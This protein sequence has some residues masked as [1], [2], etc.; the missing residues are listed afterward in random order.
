MSDDSCCQRALAIKME[1]VLTKGWPWMSWITW[2]K[3]EI[4]YNKFLLNLREI[5]CNQIRI[6]QKKNAR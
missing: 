6:S 4:H 2:I 3:A 1:Q 5:W